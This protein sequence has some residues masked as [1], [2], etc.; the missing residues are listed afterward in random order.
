MATNDVPI[1]T[2]RTEGP[3]KTQL[4]FLLGE[5]WEHGQLVSGIDKKRKKSRSWTEVKRKIVVVIVVI[6][7]TIH[8]GHGNEEIEQTYS[9]NIIFIF[10]VI[11][12]VSLSKEKLIQGK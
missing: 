2:E 7:V 5:I 8:N 3:K 4:V 9:S 10:S 11:F 6:I 1:Q 12:S